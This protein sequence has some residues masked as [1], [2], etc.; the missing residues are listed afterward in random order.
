MQ[1]V[2]CCYDY[3]ADLIAAPITYSDH[4]GARAINSNWVLDDLW[5]GRADE[6]KL[7]YDKDQLS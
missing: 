4:C 5:H 2:L 1:V 3:K 6:E 7:I